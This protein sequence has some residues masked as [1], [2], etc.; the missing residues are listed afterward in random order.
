[1]IPVCTENDTNAN[2]VC[3]CVCVCLYIYNAALMTLKVGGT[4]FTIKF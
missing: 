2:S 1:M 3:V 4:L